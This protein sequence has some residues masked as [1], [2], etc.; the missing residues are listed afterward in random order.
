MKRIILIATALSVTLAVRGWVRTDIVPFPSHYI[1]LQAG[2]GMGGLSYDLNGGTSSAAPSF[3]FGAGYTWFFLPSA[4][5]QTGVQLSWLSTTATLSEPMEWTRRQDGTPLKDYMGEEY[6]HRITFADWRERQQALLLEVPV[7]LRFRHFASADGK[8]GFHSAA[9]ALLTIPVIA[10]YTHTSGT[11]THTGWYEQW[12]LLLHDVPGR[13]ETEPYQRQRESF[14]SR[15]QPFSL[16]AYA[17]AGVLIHMGERTELAVAAYIHWMPIDWV[18]AG[19]NE[20]TQLGFANDRNGYTFMPEYHGLIGTDRT[21]VVHPWSAGV[22][23]L[24]SLWP[25][26]TNRQHKRCMCAGMK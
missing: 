23:V 13:Y 19:K 26:Q 4:G 24:L 11:L 6:A 2:A 12:R 8:F 10:N 7:G 9:G 20:R 25:G 21:G 1:D 15:V 22:K 3:F 5:F 14:L 17:E 18:S 16:T